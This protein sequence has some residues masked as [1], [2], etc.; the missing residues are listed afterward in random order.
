[1]IDITK[2]LDRDDDKVYDLFVVQNHALS[3]DPETV[4]GGQL[5]LMSQPAPKKDK[6]KIDE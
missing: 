5:L 4:E 2:I 1:V 6:N 3:G